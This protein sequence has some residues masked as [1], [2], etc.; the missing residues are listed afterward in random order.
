MK[1]TCVEL[2]NFL[3]PDDLPQK[4][5][6]MSSTDSDIRPNASARARDA[7]D[8]ANQ[9]DAIRVDLQNLT[10]TVTHIAWGQVSRDQTRPWRP[11]TRPRRPSGAIRCKP[12]PSPQD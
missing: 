6:L 12:S 10:G 9:I 3:P 8:L 5:T 7:D 2:L 1:R 4:E 11:P